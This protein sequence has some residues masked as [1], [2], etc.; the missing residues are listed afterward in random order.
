MR[1]TKI[2]IRPL[3]AR[4]KKIKRRLLRSDPGLGRVYKD[5]GAQ[6]IFTNLLAMVCFFWIFRNQDTLGDLIN[7]KQ[8]KKAPLDEPDGLTAAFA[9]IVN[10]GADVYFGDAEK[11]YFRNEAKFAEAAKEHA[12]RLAGLCA[13]GSICGAN[14][15]KAIQSCF[16]A[17]INFNFIDFYTTKLNVLSQGDEPNRYDGLVLLIERQIDY[18]NES[19]AS[20]KEANSP[21]FNFVFKTII[22]LRKKIY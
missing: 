2:N 3:V 13:D 5:L 16:E 18:L 10:F 11:D 6:T 9:A 14:V 17:L 7:P 8:I 12:A 4:T 22:T 1:K 15:A 21:N 19:Y 20:F